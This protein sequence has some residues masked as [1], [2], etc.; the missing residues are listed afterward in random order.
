MANPPLNRSM[1]D[2]FAGGATPITTPKQEER[3]PEATEARPMFREKPPSEKMSV[4][5]PK[6]L[7]EA[8]R[9]Y[10]KLTDIPMS[11]VIVE[12][13]RRELARRKRGE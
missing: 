12:G 8:L 13:A 10:M 1:V 7:Y 6:D 2:A 3:A 9:A 11:D 4:N 5:M